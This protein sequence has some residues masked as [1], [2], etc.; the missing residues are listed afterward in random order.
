ML[1][2]DKFH[3]KFPSSYFINFEHIN[4]LWYFNLF[5]KI[6]LN[7]KTLFDVIKKSRGI[8]LYLRTRIKA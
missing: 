7:I 8:Y 5:N 6:G 3:D 4:K 1:N 2:V